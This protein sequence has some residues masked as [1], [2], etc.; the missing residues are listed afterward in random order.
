MAKDLPFLLFLTKKSKKCD[1]AGN[2]SFKG[3]VYRSVNLGGRWEVLHFPPRLED[4]GLFHYFL[5]ENDEK[6]SFC[7]EFH[8]LFE[9]IVEIKKSYV[10][11]PQKPV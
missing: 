7:V 11:N 4:S 1:T 3:L 6:H 9:F 8:E 5:S 10:E 2:S